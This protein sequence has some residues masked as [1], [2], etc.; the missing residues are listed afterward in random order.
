MGRRAFIGSVASG[1]LAV[2]LARAQYPA[3]VV[4]IGILTFGVAPSAPLLEAFRQGLREKGYVEGKSIEL[5]YR[6]A[7]GKADTA[8]A[9]AAELVALKVDVIVTEGTPTALAAK[10][11]TTTIP[12]VTTLVGDP[13]QLG[14]AASLGRPGGNV[15]GLTTS[16]ADRTGKQLQTLKEI[17]P[18]IA[19]VA[20]IY[21]AA[22]P[23]SADRLKE[24]KAAAKSLK[25][26]IQFV[27]VRSPADLDAAFET[28]ISARPGALITI[29]DGMLL[30]NRKRI[31]E[32]AA[33]RRLP[34]AFPE[35]EFAEAGGLMAYGPNVAS[36]FRRAAGFVDKILKGAKPADLPIE[37]PTKFDLVINL[38]T[39][40]A[41]GLKIPPAV[42]ARADELIE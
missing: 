33:K 13:V 8:P 36:N 9:L 30:G 40:T 7:Q 21:N 34:G 10:H 2:P 19:G 31:V 17:A 14:L 1:L 5:E 35:R 39:A 38:R 26:P 12:I 22:R 6:F 24:A 32:F 16:A 28:L 15:T 23:D 18:N 41:L 37:Q 11:A 20:V 29:G 4:R 3:K 42:L 25:L 27:G